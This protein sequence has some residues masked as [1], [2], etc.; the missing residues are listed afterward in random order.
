M[1]NQSDPRIGFAR[2]EHLEPELIAT[3]I[4][5]LRIILE[6]TLV[7]QEDPA[8]IFGLVLSPILHFLVSEKTFPEFFIDRILKE[9]FPRMN[10]RIY[11]N[12][13]KRLN[14]IK[15]KSIK[16]FKT[17]FNEQIKFANFCLG[18]KAD[19]SEREQFSHLKRRFRIGS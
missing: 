18:S 15:F 8:R 17:Y 1:K 14:L 3:W 16:T 9:N 13:L 4:S 5:Q 6:T 7:S 12:K 19:M 11:E 10:F 2:L